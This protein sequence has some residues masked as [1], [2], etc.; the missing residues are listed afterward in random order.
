MPP[1]P[2]GLGPEYAAQFNDRA[3]VE[4]YGARPPYPE[5]LLPAIVEIAGHPRPRLLDLGCG[6]GELARRLAPQVESIT[7]VDASW[8]MI[9]RAQ[10]LPGGDAPNIEWVVS[11]VE[12]IDRPDAFTLAI[13]AESFH[14]FDWARVCVGV[15]RHVPSGALVLVEGRIERDTPWAG[16]L[17]ALIARYS[18][19]RDYEP[20]DLVAEL[21]GRSCFDVRGRSILGPEPFRQTPAD[22]IESIHS[23]NGFSR[24]RMPPGEA[25][26]FDLAVAAL[27]AD[28][29][30]DGRIE[31]SIE[32]RV[33]WGTVI[34]VPGGR[35]A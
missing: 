4:A 7:A 17:G 3:V 30:R 27:L 24:D 33:T 20:Y 1:K 35:A 25:R 9:V 16:E 5:A 22:Y 12:D 14:W 29:V 31:L 18:T 19:N 13:A 23:R 26:Q 28:H 32:T 15:R 6:T 8:R 2:R 11:P 10:S 21:A 34:V